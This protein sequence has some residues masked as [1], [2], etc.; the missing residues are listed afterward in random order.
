MHN[1]ALARFFFG[2]CAGV[3]LCAYD[4]FVMRRILNAPPA[5]VENM[6]FTMTRQL[7]YCNFSHSLKTGLTSM[8]FIK[9]NKTSDC[10]FYL[11]FITSALTPLVKLVSETTLE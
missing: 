10:T 1:S 8:H 5:Q 6:H 2:I 3:K 4:L 11:L 7:Q 9:I